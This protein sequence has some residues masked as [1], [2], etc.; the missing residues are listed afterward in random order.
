MIINR[1]CVETWFCQRFGAREKLSIWHQN[2]ETRYNE[3]VQCRFYTYTLTRNCVCAVGKCCCCDSLFPKIKIIDWLV[4]CSMRLFIF[5]LH[6]VSSFI[7][8]IFRISIAWYF[9]IIIM[10]KRVDA[11][12][13]KWTLKTPIYH[14]EF[15]A[16]RKQEWRKRTKLKRT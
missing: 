10:S 6:Y 13:G 1:W 15:S 2:S 3:Y 5:V 11:S 9:K 14:Y 4:D 8:E 7:P 16:D 12:V